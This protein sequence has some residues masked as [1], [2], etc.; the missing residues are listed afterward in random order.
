MKKLVLY[1]LLLMVV[2]ASA[3]SGLFNVYPNHNTSYPVEYYNPGPMMHYGPHGDYAPAPPAYGMSPENFD[4][5]L[6]YLSKETFDYKRL[7]VGKQ[8][9]RNNWVSARQIASMCEL[10]T[11]D[12]N[13]LDFAKYAYASCVDK[14]MYFLLDDT[15]I[16]R[17]SIDEL[18]DYIRER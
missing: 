5:V 7:E 14:G 6:V 15:F 8:V 13:R 4:A 3:Q 2:P 11:Y 9:V 18:H 10:F 1:F 12:Y 17:F 16:Y